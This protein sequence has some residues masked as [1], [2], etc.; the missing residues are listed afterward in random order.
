MRDILI[1]LFLKVQMVSEIMK[2]FFAL[3]PLTIITLIALVV[4]VIVTFAYKWLTDQKRMKKLRDDLNDYQKEM[5][6]TK[7]IKK[8]STI[9]KKAFEANLEYMKHSFKPTLWTM[10]PVLIIFIWL[11]SFIAYEPINPGDNFTVTVNLEKGS[12]GT[13]KLVDVLPTGVTLLDKK[14][15]EI[16][17]NKAEFKLRAEREGLYT[18]TFNH[19][20]ETVNKDVLVS[21]TRQYKEPIQA[22][23]DLSIK[24][25]VIDQDYTKPFGQS[26]NLFG[27]YPGWLATYIILSIIFSTALRKIMGLY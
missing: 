13:I 6:D 12:A 26:F 20:S 25:V 5:R 9:Q 10:L 17:N 11:N 21:T 27:W 24:Q 16:V 8:L 18:M 2:S 3:H 23:K 15:K 4:T 22:Y 1:E 19:A 7:D 14:E